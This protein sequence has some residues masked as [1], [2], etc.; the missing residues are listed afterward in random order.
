MHVLTD[1]SGLEAEGCTKKASLNHV[2]HERHSIF[3]VI[4][5]H[6]LGHTMLCRYVQVSMLGNLTIVTTAICINLQFTSD[7]SHI[8]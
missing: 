8:K 4:N 6:G 5:V 2:N 3:Y 1:Q 7:A